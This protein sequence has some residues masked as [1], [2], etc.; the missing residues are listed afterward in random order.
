MKSHVED[1]S[2]LGSGRTLSIT[3]QA[4]VGLTRLKLIAPRLRSPGLSFPICRSVGTCLEGLI[5]E[6]E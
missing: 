2:S 3:P 6:Y 1:S 4:T 5:D